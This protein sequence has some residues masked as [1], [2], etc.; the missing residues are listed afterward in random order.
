MTDVE[1]AKQHL[2]GHT[3][4][5]CKDGAFLYSECRGIAPMIRFME[6][7]MDLSGYS[8]ADLVV[9]KAAALLFVKAGVT[10]VYART[11]SQGAAQILERHGIPYTC[12][13]LTEKIMNRAGTDICPMEKAVADTQDCEAAYHNILRQLE[14]MGI[15]VKMA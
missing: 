7:R 15:S 11:L 6:A 4:C 5:L 13:I 8:A 3:I 2:A 9:G 14:H 12:D 10:A 1:L